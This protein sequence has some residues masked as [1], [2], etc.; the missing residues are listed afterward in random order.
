VRPRDGRWI[1]GLGLV[2]VLVSGHSG[3]WRL[4]A[5]MNAPAQDQQPPQAPEAP[6]PPDAVS[7]FVTRSYRVK[8]KKLWKSLLETLQSAGYPP[9][10]VDESARRVKTSFVDF[11]EKNFPQ[12]VGGDPP[13]FTPDYPILQQIKVKEGKVSLE[14]VVAPADGGA[15]LSLRARLLVH[16]LDRRRRLRV[17]TDRRSSG[18]IETTI[19]KRLEDE[20]GIKPI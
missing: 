8:P 12:P 4:W 5:A 16:G 6:I 20:L 3:G 10:D 17:M 15:Q 14:A 18:V 19:F 11:D 13:E 1:L 9:E 2:L 7:S